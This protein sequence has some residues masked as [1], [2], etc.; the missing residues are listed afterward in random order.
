M[1]SKNVRMRSPIWNNAC[2]AGEV[3][4]SRIYGVPRS[5]AAAMRGSKDTRPRS[6]T[7]R[8]APSGDVGKKSVRI[9]SQVGHTYEL[10]F[11]T[12]P[13]TGVQEITCQGNRL[14]HDEV[15]HC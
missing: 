9:C 4:Y 15:R 1:V 11:Y 3:P 6:R 8:R 7:H 12:S 2:P 5:P 14:Q 13:S 10:M